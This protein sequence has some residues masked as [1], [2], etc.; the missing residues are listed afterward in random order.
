MSLTRR[1]VRH[2]LEMTRAELIREIERTMGDRYMEMYGRFIDEMKRLS[3][4]ATVVILRTLKPEKEE[5]E[6][7]EKSYL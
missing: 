6:E 1:G 5:E 4:V 2:P 7:E 3:L